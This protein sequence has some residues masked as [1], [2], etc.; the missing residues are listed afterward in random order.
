M[1]IRNHRTVVVVVLGAL[2]AS[3]SAQSLS[4]A[5]SKMRCG[6]H[7]VDAVSG[8]PVRA[9]EIS[10]TSLSAGGGMAPNPAYTDAN[11]RFAIDNLEPGRYVLRA[12]RDSYTSPD[13]PSGPDSVLWS[14]PRLNTSKTRLFP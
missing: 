3:A 13:H 11:G 9:A 14:L 1:S 10:A 8:Q 12:S 2:L 6:G 5:Q 7:G 4:N